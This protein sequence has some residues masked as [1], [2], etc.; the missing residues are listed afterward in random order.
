MSSFVGALRLFGD[1]LGQIEEINIKGLDV[2][3][4]IVYKYNL[5]FV[6]ILD[7]EFIKHNIREEAE[8]SLDMFY[9][10]YRREIE[11]NSME[12]SQFSSFKNIL[13]TQ[14]EEYFNRIKER[15]TEPEIGDFGFFTQAIKQLRTNS[16]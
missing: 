6:A 4:V 3:M 15:Q 8:K 5:I 13:L 9:S 10:L 16:S 7:K 11:E 1:N 12:V 2:Q 14:V